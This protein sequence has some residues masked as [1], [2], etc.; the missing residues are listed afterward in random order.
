MH[1]TSNSATSRSLSFTT[2]GG[3]AGS[4]FSTLTIDKT[5]PQT[6]ENQLPKV[7]VNSNQALQVAP[8]SSRKWPG[9]C[10]LTGL[11]ACGVSFLNEASLEKSIGIGLVAGATL[12]SLVKVSQKHLNPTVQK[13]VKTPSEMIVLP[14][15]NEMPEVCIPIGLGSNEGNA[16]PQPHRTTTD[17]GT[18]VWIYDDRDV[19]EYNGN[20]GYALLTEETR[21]SFEALTRQ[22]PPTVA[23]MTVYYNNL[24]IY[25]K[26]LPVIF[27]TEKT[28]PSALDA[29]T[30]FTAAIKQR[31]N[32]VQTALQRHHSGK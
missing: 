21:P 16:A 6:L 29:Q 5:S 13:P 11:V 9:V 10:V 27:E 18:E 2:G 30:A 31:D 22:Y 23:N 4:P 19:E 28:F 17:D 25:T 26:F 20:Q 3:A 12:F 15:L 14:A 8:A 1:H 24:Y 32:L 7:I